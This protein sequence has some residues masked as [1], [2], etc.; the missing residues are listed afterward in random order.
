MKLGDYCEQEGYGD[1]YLMQQDFLKFKLALDNTTD[2][3]YVGLI[4]SGV[5]QAIFRAL[6]KGIDQEDIS[7]MLEYARNSDEIFLE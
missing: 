6:L 7:D 3:E 4:G 2:A 1:E 5:S